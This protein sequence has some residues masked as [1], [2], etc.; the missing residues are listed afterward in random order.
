M[1]VLLHHFSLSEQN[2]LFAFI[3][4]ILI[5]FTNSK[6]DFFYL[7]PQK[8]ILVLSVGYCTTSLG[9]CRLLLSY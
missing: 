8:S 9:Y 1:L 3:F 4:K 2:S 7:G 5:Y 6:R